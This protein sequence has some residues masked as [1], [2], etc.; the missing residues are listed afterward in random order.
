VIEVRKIVAVFFLALFGLVNLHHAFPHVHHEHESIA[1]TELTAEVHHHH[2][3]SDHHHHSDE[4]ENDQDQKNLFDFL[5]KNHSHTK[6]TH[7]YTPA[8]VKHV[9]SVKQIEIKIFGSSDS[10]EFASKETD[11]GLHQY[12]LFDNVGSDDSFLYSN[13][14]RGPPA[15]G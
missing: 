15:L 2:H 4:E 3:D 11:V 8:I 7:Q 1:G 6:H 10:W 12:A 9:K 5:F 13:P 14:L